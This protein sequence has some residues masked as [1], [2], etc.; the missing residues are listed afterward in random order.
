M[1]IDKKSRRRIEMVK[2]QKES[3]KA[4]FRHASLKHAGTGTG[5]SK[6]EPKK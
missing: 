6:T 3:F 2:E 1:A 5:N 4:L